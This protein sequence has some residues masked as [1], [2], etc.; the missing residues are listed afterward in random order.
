MLAAE[1]ISAWLVE[2]KQDF[3]AIPA[4]AFFPGRFLGRDVKYKEG[5]GWGL[6]PVIPCWASCSERSLDR[7][8]LGLG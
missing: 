4:L 2:Q 5:K 1:G 3:S 7:N 6:C 8:E